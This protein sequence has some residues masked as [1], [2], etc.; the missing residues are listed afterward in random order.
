M[1]GRGREHVL[2]WFDTAVISISLYFCGPQLSAP[3]LWAKALKYF[4]RNKKRLTAFRLEEIWKATWWAF[5]PTWSRSHA[6]V[7]NHSLP[8]RS[9]SPRVDVASTVVI[10]APRGWR[11]TPPSQCLLEGFQG[12]RTDSLMIWQG[13][14]D[15]F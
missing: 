2:F 5:L 11:V 6:W 14:Q 15:N 4:K 13:V 3:A 7:C 10:E 1:W 9:R 8:S 12:L